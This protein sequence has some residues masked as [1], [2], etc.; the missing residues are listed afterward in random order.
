MLTYRFTY[1]GMRLNVTNRTLNEIFSYRELRDE[2][3]SLIVVVCGCGSVDLRRYVDVVNVIFIHIF[4]LWIV[5]NRVILLLFNSNLSVLGGLLV[6]LNS[7]AT[8]IYLPSP[9]LFIVA[10]PSNHS[11]Q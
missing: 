9:D 3:L 7:D 4:G 1:H 6:Q 2:L 10:L 8:C 11:R 5:N